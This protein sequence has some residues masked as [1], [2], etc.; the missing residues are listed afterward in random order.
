MFSFPEKPNL[1]SKQELRKLKPTT[2]SINGNP[3]SIKMLKIADNESPIISQKLQELKIDTNINQSNQEHTNDPLYNFQ[4]DEIKPEQN[5][6]LLESIKNLSILFENKEITFKPQTRKVLLI[7]SRYFQIDS[8][9]ASLESYDELV[10]SIEEEVVN[11]DEMNLLATFE[12]LLMNFNEDIFEGTVD[13]C[14][15][16]LQKMSPTLFVYSIIRF[17]SIRYEKSMIFLN[18]LKRIDEVNHSKSNHSIFD[19]FFSLIENE[20]IIK[21]KEIDVKRLISY[22]Q[23]FNENQT[24]E[25]SI[26]SDSIIES[27]EKDDVDTMQKI[28]TES[29]FDI[30]KKIDEKIIKNDFSLPL[31]FNVTYIKYAASKGSVKCFKYLLINEANVDIENT[32]LFAVSGGN[33]EIIHLCE[34]KNCSF[35]GTIKISIKNHLHE[36]TQWLI[37]NNKDKSC[38]GDEFFVKSPLKYCVRYC[39]FISLK[40]VISFTKDLSKILLSSSKYNN[41]ILTRLSIKIMKKYPCQPISIK[42]KEYYPIS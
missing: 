9:T 38:I 28:L 8:L 24:K 26:V 2:F 7:L 39:N 11:S 35:E 12:E 15:G 40:Y 30:N 1:Y 33:P 37:D 32:A 34:Q 14:I 22:K 21:S 25:E 17:I 18:L 42:D 6:E 31:K 29:Q 10:D 13:K 20:N 16:I 4:I 41:E 36:I 19:L 3:I 27:I 23:K 5:S